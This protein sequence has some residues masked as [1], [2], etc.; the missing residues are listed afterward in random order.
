[1]D[2]YK[3]IGHPNQLFGAVPFQYTQGRAAGVKGFMV[4]NGAGI[5]MTVLQDRCLD[6]S[7]LSYKGINLSYL[8]KGGITSPH[9]Y[10]K[11]GFE[12]L[13]SFNV[14]FL[15]TCGL[16]HIGAP[17]EVE[18]EKFGLHGRIGNTPAEEVSSYITD[19]P[20]APV[21]KIKGVMREGEIFK[22]NLLLTR[23][24]EVPVAS[25]HFHIKNRI[26][27]R[28]YRREAYMMMLHFNAGYPLLDSNAEF[29]ADS[30]EVEPRDVE[31][32][33]GF[34]TYA[35][36]DDPHD[37]YPEQVFFHRLK[38]DAEGETTVTLFNHKLGIGVA[39]S[40]NVK[41][42]PYLTQW[43]QFAKGDYVFGMEPSTCKML[44][45]AALAQR[46][47]LSYL[48]PGESVDLDIKVTLIEKL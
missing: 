19:D 24:I 40:Y 18:G 27:N 20:E 26:T 9:Y 31:A 35:K 30:V 5:E 6:I 43:K 17:C 38:G 12:F 41:N 44:G 48:D 32:Q 33:K 8:S 16:R 39:L 10:D 14:G 23:E 34:E 11:E 2:I 37:L 36:V 42:F 4:N 1:M 47:E 29:I 46:G 45:R 13:K 3:Y 22:E 25:D 7:A 15:T 28:A 21:I